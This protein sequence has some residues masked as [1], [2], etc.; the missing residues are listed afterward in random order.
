MCF[1]LIS[2]HVHNTM[3]MTAVNYD[4]HCIKHSMYHTG[5]ALRLTGKFWYFT[6]LDQDIPGKKIISQSYQLLL[7]DGLSETKKHHTD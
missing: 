7:F 3:S 5:F 1:S 2:V 4:C 6:G